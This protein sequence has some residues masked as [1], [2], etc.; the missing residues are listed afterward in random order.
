MRLQLKVNIVS[1][2]ILVAVACALTA[3][4]VAAMDRLAYD[5]NRKLLAAEAA[6]LATKIEEAQEVLADSGVAA[7]RSYVERT[8]QDLMEE[9]RRDA[10]GLFGHLTILTSAGR[11]VL[12][13]EEG[14]LENVE[15]PCLRE[16]VAHGQGE[17][18]CRFLG[19]RRLVFYR[20]FPDWDWVLLLSAT[21][22]EM[23]AARGVFL[24][25]ALLILAASLVMGGGILL[26]L[27]RGFVGPLQRLAEAAMALSRGEWRQP[28]PEP[29]GKDEVGELSRS[30]AV[31]AERLEQAHGSLAARAD[32]LRRVNADLHREVGERRK[33]EEELAWLNRDLED[34]VAVRTSEL[35]GKAE[36]L[37]EANRR[38]L[39]MDEL[40]SAFLSSVSHELRTPLTSVLGFTKL[41]GKDFEASF[42][43][44]AR[45]E[46][47]RKKGLRISGNLRI[48]EQE[49]ERLTRLINDFLDLTKI[50][51]G[52]VEWCDRETDVADA[53]RQALASVRGVFEQNPDV[54]LAFT[55]AE[56]LPPVLADPDRLEQVFI[57]ILNNAAKFTAEGVVTIGVGLAEDGY[58]QVRM[59]DTGVGIPQ[60]DLDKVFDK[61]HQVVH[62][63]TR[64]AKPQG[65]GL[66]L[67]ICR[68]IV[69]HYGG[70][71]WAESAP[72]QG[73]VF[74]VELPPAPAA[75]ACAA[76]GPEPG[77]PL[78][79]VA[80]DDPAICSFLTQVFTDAGFAVAYAADG[81]EVL[82]L[83]KRH[84]PDL[85]TMDILMPGLDGRQ[86]MA[87][88]REDPEL[89]AIPILVLSV[90][91][92]ERFG[93]E[94]AALRKPVEPGDL[95][96]A[97]FGLLNRSRPSRPVLV[98]RRNGP[99]HLGPFFTLCQGDIDHLTEGELW[100]KIEDGFRGT[101][102]IPGWA[103]RT[104]DLARLRGREG[105]QV[106]ILPE[107]PQAGTS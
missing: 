16:M 28:L 71:I 1:L 34:Q 64:R 23:Y 25:N 84:K 94:D 51:S 78:V 103:A 14:A 40:K 91:P 67:A 63:D 26:S 27:T 77:K 75:E 104:A 45:E 100:G 10:P 96:D 7:V 30:F 21:D 13:L 85:I 41:I 36:E 31:M 87:R 81:H 52:R 12:A 46:V 79:L 99:E 2:G 65:T 97:A 3:A 37:R 88:L 82:D 11:S 38:L 17:M 95:L 35:A 9:F 19:K 66:G 55:A 18:D 92:E 89:S 15:P 8:Q 58:V 69:R 72:G 54:R 102:I 61:F 56:G 57:N 98:L 60:E 20:T 48:I 76:A 43:P 62:R 74:T 29:R 93:G 39:D 5:L 22:Q 90:L 59:A 4:G 73:C 47:L 86:A 32:D 68:Q 49:G 70:R 50:E 107:R 44:L 101:V 24:Q 83:A 6:G 53:V 80:D 106:L 105:V 42:L 33:A